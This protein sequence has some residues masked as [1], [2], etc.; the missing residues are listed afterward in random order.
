VNGLNVLSKLG[1]RGLDEW[2]SK[3]FQG[4]FVGIGS[5]IGFAVNA[6]CAFC[7]CREMSWVILAVEH[8]VRCA[9]SAG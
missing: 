8:N 2:F 9:C 4:R 6:K 1:G 7:D 3:Q 5:G